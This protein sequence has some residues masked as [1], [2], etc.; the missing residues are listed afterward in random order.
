MEQYT[1]SRFNEVP[2]IVEGKFF[3][4]IHQ[5]HIKSY[6]EKG[7][8]NIVQNVRATYCKLIEQL[9]TCWRN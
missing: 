3:R 4:K 1:I 2:S 6:G 9:I 8:N 5:K 7:A